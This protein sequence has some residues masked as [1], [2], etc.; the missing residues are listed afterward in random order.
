MLREVGYIDGIQGSIIAGWAQSGPDD[1]NAAI[2]EI[3]IDGEFVG[4]VSACTYRE[5]LAQKSICGGLAGFS[6]SI[7]SKYFDGVQHRIDCRIAHCQ[8]PLGDSPRV[9]QFSI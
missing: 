7:P 5:D 8:S 4:A 2:V 6:Y 3:L 1:T 9:V